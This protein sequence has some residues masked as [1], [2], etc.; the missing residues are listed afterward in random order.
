MIKCT[1]YEVLR[2]SNT[3]SKGFL[4]LGRARARHLHLASL[5]IRLSL[6]S[7]TTVHHGL[8]TLFTR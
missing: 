4:F 7:K 1:S 2:N 8:L 5:R 3:H 6:L